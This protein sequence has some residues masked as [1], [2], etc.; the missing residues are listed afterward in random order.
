MKTLC[1]IAKFSEFNSTSPSHIVNTLSH[2]FICVINVTFLLVELKI[3][4]IFLKIYIFLLLAINPCAVN[5][6]GCTHL[7]LLSSVKPDGYSCACPTDVKLY[8]DGRHCD[9][10]M[11]LLIFPYFPL[12]T[13]GKCLLTFPY[14]PLSIFY[15][16]RKGFYILNV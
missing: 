16:R 3:T 5:N 11:Y 6:G 8:P 14:F 13:F 15:Y 10:G 4:L 7:C 12:D 1:S 2:L 9:I